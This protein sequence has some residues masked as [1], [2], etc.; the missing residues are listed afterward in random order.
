[1]VYVTKEIQMKVRY[2]AIDNVVVDGVP[3]PAG[4]YSG[5]L[6]Y[7]ADPAEP[8][9]E[10]SPEYTIDLSQADLETIE[11]WQ[12]SQ[13]LELLATANVRDGSLRLL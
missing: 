11:G 13:P 2:E 8:M 3:L 10:V 12:G 6:A 4:R 5:R 9:A 1:M 7:L